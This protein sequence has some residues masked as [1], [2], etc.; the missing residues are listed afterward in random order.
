MIKTQTG[1]ILPL[2]L[3]ILSVLTAFAVTLSQQ[4]RN[5]LTVVME[6][7]QQW[8][9]EL[10]YRSVLQQVVQHLILGE[11]NYNAVLFNGLRL[12]I[13]GEVITIDG[14][15][16]QVQDSAGL[17]GLG[18]YDPK[19]VLRLFMQVTDKNTA[20]KIRDQLTDWIDAD[21]LKHRS[22]MEKRDYMFAG[23]N[24]LP[25]NTPLRHLDELLEL[26]A[27]NAKI[28]NQ[29]LGK[30]PLRQHLL[31]S[32]Y[33]FLNVATA[34][35][36]VLKAVLDLSPQKLAYVIRARKQG[37][38]K[39]LE[40]RLPLFHSAFDEFGPFIPSIVYRVKIS[41]ADAP[42]LTTIIRLKRLLTMPYQTQIWY[43][44]DDARG[45]NS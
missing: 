26:P 40:K 1:A 35:E 16:V 17:L 37:A 10:K 41:Q 24:Y 38:W 15:N 39:A 11:N 7:Q 13:D 36:A 44:P 25:R 5:S 42:T 30:Y 45:W 34:T 9:Q 8:Q 43:Y 19:V 18:N 27:M 33:G 14:V 22:G 31:V 3:I 2:T 32:G 4:A 28:Y 29:I 20:L 23:L 6:Q 21:S 12:P